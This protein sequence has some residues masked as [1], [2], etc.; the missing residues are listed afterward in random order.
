MVRHEGGRWDVGIKDAAV[1]VE[2]VSDSDDR[3]FEDSLTAQEAR[4]L[5]GLL[6][7]Y[8]DK[9]DEARDAD[10][11]KESGKSDE[12]EDSEDSGKAEESEKSD[13]PEDSEDSGEAEESEKSDESKKSDESDE[14]DN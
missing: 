14:S 13:E 6:T 4:D 5:A 9:L 7:K 12:P 10:K 3:V 2:R 8:A 11:A 1:Y